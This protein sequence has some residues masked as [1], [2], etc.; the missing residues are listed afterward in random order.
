MAH[1]TNYVDTFIAVAPDCAAQQGT[2]PKES[3]KP[4]VALRAFRLIS[5]HPYRFTSDD[6]LFTIYADRSEIPQGKRAAA[7]KAFFAKPQ[8]CLRGS[9][10]CKRY[11]WG[12]HHDGKGR[13]ALY[14]IESAEYAK[15]ASGKDPDGNPITVRPALRSARK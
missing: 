10:L 7:R 12:V 4:S 1:S 15:L 14:G 2:M 8:A 3:E 9:D 6:V 13:I 5:E 11:G